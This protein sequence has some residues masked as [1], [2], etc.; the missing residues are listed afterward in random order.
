MISVLRTV[1]RRFGF[2][3]SSEVRKANRFKTTFLVKERCY[4]AMRLKN[5]C[6]G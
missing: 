2:R 6:R 3:L 1:I 5:N 4:S